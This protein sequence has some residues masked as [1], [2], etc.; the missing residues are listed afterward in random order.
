MQLLEHTLNE[1]EYD[2][3][4]YKRRNTEGSITKSYRFVDLTVMHVC[5]KFDRNQSR[6][7]ACE[8]HKISHKISTKIWPLTL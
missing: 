4:P 1:A 7:V 3:W 2:L 5:E 6:N 8:K